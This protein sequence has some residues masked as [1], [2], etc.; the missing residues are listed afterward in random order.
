MHIRTMDP[1]ETPYCSTRA[2]TWSNS[3]CVT[4]TLSALGRPGFRPS[5]VRRVGLLMRLLL[6]TSALACNSAPME[7]TATREHLERRLEA[8]ADKA[9]SRELT[10]EQAIQ[11][12]WIRVQE[13]QRALLD[14]APAEG[15]PKRRQIGKSP[16]GLRRWWDN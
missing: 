16:D 13:Q 6:H 8:L 10:P 11:E 2:R 12:A 7:A 14:G 3:A 4:R 5:T 9:E 1:D 15:S